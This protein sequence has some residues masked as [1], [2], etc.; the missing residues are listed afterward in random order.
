MSLARNMPE[1][2]SQRPLVIVAGLRP[3]VLP[4]L[5]STLKI[6]YDRAAGKHLKALVC[7]TPNISARGGGLGH[8]CAVW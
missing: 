2:R 8:A 7:I 6:C 1:V 4:S 3:A 5:Y